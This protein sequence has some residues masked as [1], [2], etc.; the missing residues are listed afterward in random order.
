MDIMAAVGMNDKD[1]R[2]QHYAGLATITTKH[3]A[4]HHWQLSLLNKFTKTGNELSR[5]HTDH[6]KEIYW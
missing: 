1:L 4:L 3:G 5:H 6:V 2:L